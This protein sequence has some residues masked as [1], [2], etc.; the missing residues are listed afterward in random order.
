MTIISVKT[1]SNN[2][3]RITLVIASFIFSLGTLLIYFNNKN[4][5]VPNHVKIA[6]LDSGLSKKIYS[7]VIV[8]SYEKTTDTHADIM[9]KAILSKIEKNNQK[10]I[11]II[12]YSVTSSGTNVSEQKVLTALQ[13]AID[14][15]VDIINMSFGFKKDI[16]E[17]K[18]LIN[19]AKWIP[20]AIA[21][22]GVIIRGVASVA[23]K[24]LTKNSIKIAGKTYKGQPKKKAKKALKDYKGDT[25]KVGKTGKVVKMG[26]NTLEHIL[27]EH[28]LKYWKGEEKKTFFDPNL[29]IKTIRNYMKQT[30]STNVKNIKNGSKKKGAIIT[31]TKKI[32]KV[33]YKMAIRVDAKGAM[34]VSSFYPAERK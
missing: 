15:D 2:C 18:E 34:T 29:K 13:K 1:I 24:N 19:Q 11:T 12:D 16:P 31:I 14:Q 25:F 17:L 22:G 3:N 30:I 28:H 32:N 7:E 4:V 10:K 8:E 27:V 33:T 20:I 23:A 5:V 21:I 26:S 9:L 6:L